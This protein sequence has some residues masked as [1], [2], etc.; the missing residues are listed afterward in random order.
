MGDCVELKDAK[1]RLLPPTAQTAEKSAGY[2]ALSIKKALKGKQSKPFTAKVDGVF[3]ALGG[4]YAVGSL[5]NIIR[6]KGYKAYLLKKLITKGYYLGL[7]LRIN[8]GYKK[9][10]TP[11]L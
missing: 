3:V 4:E 8:T 6:V 7:K 5:F 11:P 1:E 2:V 10:T 9:R